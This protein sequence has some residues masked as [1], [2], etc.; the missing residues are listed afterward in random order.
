M[1]G[2]VLNEVAQSDYRQRFQSNLVDAADSSAH[3]HYSVLIAHI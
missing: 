1:T 2:G 3:W